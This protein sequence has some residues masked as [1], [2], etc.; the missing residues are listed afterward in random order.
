MYSQS[1]QKPIHSSTTSNVVA[2][3]W[4]FNCKSNRCWAT[5]QEDKQ[6]TTNWQTVELNSLLQSETTQMSCAHWRR[7]IQSQ[8][9]MHSVCVYKLDAD[10]NCLETCFLPPGNRSPNNCSLLVTPQQL[11]TATY[12]PLP[13]AQQNVTAIQYN[14]R[15]ITS[16]CFFLVARRLWSHFYSSVTKPLVYLIQN[17]KII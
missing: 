9:N 12:N 14:H 1:S 2:A 11:V 5:I 13:H 4:R 17:A 7:L 8:C 15:A 16:C 6:N 3:G 10:C